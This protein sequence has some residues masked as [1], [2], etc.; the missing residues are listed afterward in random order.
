MGYVTMSPRK[1]HWIATKLVHI[2]MSVYKFLSSRHRGRVMHIIGIVHGVQWR[3]GVRNLW[4]VCCDLQRTRAV[5][6]SRGGNV[7]GMHTLAPEGILGPRK[8]RYFLDGWF[9][10]NPQ[11]QQQQQLQQQN[12][13]QWCA[14]A[15]ATGLKR[16]QQRHGLSCRL[17]LIDLILW[18]MW[19][20]VSK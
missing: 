10:C 12:N 8:S 4:T 13:S 17:P 18:I 2:T 1:L 14:V 7:S 15:D 5:I 6:F 3:I 16:R 9:L 19:V 11:Q 20:L